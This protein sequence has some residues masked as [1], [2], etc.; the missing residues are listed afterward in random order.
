MMSV[1]NNK[2]NDD[3]GYSLH[4]MNNKLSWNVYGPQ[5]ILCDTGFA[6]DSQTLYHDHLK[7]HTA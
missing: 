4:K 6:A 5:A 2:Q 1:A 3:C 7:G